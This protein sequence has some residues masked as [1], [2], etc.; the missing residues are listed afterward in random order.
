[1]ASTLLLDRSTWDL[2]LDVDNNIAVATEPYALAQDAAS[3]CKV[4]KSECYYDT[5]RGIPYIDVI[6]GKNVPLSLVKSYLTNEATRINGVVTAKAYITSLSDRNLGAQ[7][8][9]TDA[10]GTSLAV[11]I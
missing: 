11:N 1:M 2:V 9:M 10:S 3:S 4:F 8:Q 7:V 6:F 5:T